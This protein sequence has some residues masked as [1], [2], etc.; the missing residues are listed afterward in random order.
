[1]MVCDHA[2]LK[3]MRDPS[4]MTEAARLCIAENSLYTRAGTVRAI[5]G[6]IIHANLPG[7][8]IGEV[9]KI[10]APHANGARQLGEAVGFGQ[11]SVIICLAG[12]IQ[13]ISANAKVIGTGQ[14]FSF[15]IGDALLGRVVDAFGQPIDDGPSL[16]N[17][18][19]VERQ[20]ALRPLDP[21]R[22]SPIESI[23]KTGIRSI[24]ACT[25]LGVGQ[26]VGL[27]G[28]SG[29]G[30]SVLMGMISRGC[31]ADVVVIGLIGERGREVGEF[32]ARELPK[33]ARARCLTVVST[34]DS[35]PLERIWGARLAITSAEYFREQGKSVLLLMDSL[36]RYARARR[37]IALQAGEMP[38][39][40][41]FPPSV[42]D[43][44]PVLLERAGNS[45]KGSIT[46][47]YTVLQDGDLRTDMLSEE[48]KSLVDG[49]IVLSPTLATQGHYPAIDVMASR[50]RLMSHVAS[51]ENQKLAEK[52]ISAKAKYDEVELLIQVGEY[53]KGTDQDADRAIELRPWING[54][55][56]QDRNELSSYD[57]TVGALK[58]GLEE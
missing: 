1:M 41:G 11:G 21:L 14:P 12:P 20:M 53:E 51:L 58:Q 43:E 28:S 48:V 19:L 2:S 26:R 5:Q 4:Q 29:A 49:H 6:T 27:F 50:S 38:I 40:Q 24:D 8:I 25:T 17:A 57:E 23:M 45:D 46:A 56:K 33:E 32:L 36:T 47:I 44:L 35:S 52:L 42:F 7:A 18:S 16:E 9:C 30:K 10:T 55:L 37:E 15:K 3:R 34:S 39:R 22:R 13:G 31:S 54:F